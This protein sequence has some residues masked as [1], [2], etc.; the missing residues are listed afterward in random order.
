MSV[1]TDA[2]DKWKTSYPA[3][4]KRGWGVTTKAEI[5]NGRHAMFGMLALWI[6]AFMK[7]HGLIPG[8][9][10]TLDLSQ[11]GTLADLGGGAPITKE[12]AIVLIAHVH[13]LVV[14]VAA[15]IA[16]FSFQD[17]LL[18]EPGE[19]DPEAAGLIPGTKLGLTAEAE[20]WNGRLAMLGKLS[21]HNDR[22]LCTRLRSHVAELGVTMLLCPQVLPRS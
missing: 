16:P 21:P 3:F 2:M 20:V 22:E 4:A 11:W 10:E 13:V 6:T 5:W 12:R 19:T 8:G 15:A 9:A 18:L 7:G 17:R 14:S 1:F